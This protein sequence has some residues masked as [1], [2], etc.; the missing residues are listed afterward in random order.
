MKEV[1]PFL[2]QYPQGSSRE[3][4]GKHQLP[5]RSFQELDGDDSGKLDPHEVLIAM[6]SIVEAGKIGD[7]GSWEPNMFFFF[8]ESSDRPIPQSF[9]FP[10]ICVPSWSDRLKDFVLNILMVLRVFSGSGRD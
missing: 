8:K 7:I 9:S 5:L 6:A 1:C 2:G 4:W 10:V 3:C